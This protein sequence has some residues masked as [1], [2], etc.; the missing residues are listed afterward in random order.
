[1]NECKHETNEIRRRTKANGAVVVAR[2]CLE[3]GTSLGELPKANYKVDELM[4]YD[5]TMNQIWREKK[6]VEYLE[7]LPQKEKEWWSEYEAYLQTYH[8]ES[9]RKEVLARDPVCRVC[10]VKLSVQAHHIS[11]ESFN[12][13]GIS[14]A[15]ECVGVC[16]ECHYMLHDKEHK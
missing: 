1:M 6:R 2:Q 14:F 9:V 4:A 11:Y 10:L 8:W 7:S 13:H 3:C 16:V 12:K 5:D 15:P